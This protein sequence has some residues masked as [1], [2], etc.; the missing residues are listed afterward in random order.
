MVRRRQTTPKTRRGR[1]N[2]MKTKEQIQDKIQ[3]L[4]NQ[5]EKLLPAD[6]YEEIRNL[7]DER[8][9]LLKW[10]IE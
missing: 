10:V 8:I 2:K 3:H 6:N 4:E 1:D 9:K 7:F 5:R